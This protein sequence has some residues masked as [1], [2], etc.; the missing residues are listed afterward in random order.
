MTRDGKQI[1]HGL[2]SKTFKDAQEEV[3][4]IQ[5]GVQA[6]GLSVQDFD[7]PNQLSVTSGIEKFS[8]HA[9]KSKKP[10][11]VSGYRLNLS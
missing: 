5:A 6:K 2:H 8:E 11:T 3:A 10:K 4:N 9:T 1:W 7:N